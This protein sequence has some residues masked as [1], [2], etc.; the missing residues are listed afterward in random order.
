MSI[1]TTCVHVISQLFYTCDVA[2]LHDT[3]LSHKCR[4]PDTLLVP[5]GAGLHGVF[6]CIR[7]TSHTSPRAVTMK[8]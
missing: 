5:L 6:S 4:G 1:K 7:A 2:Y 8:L 3:C